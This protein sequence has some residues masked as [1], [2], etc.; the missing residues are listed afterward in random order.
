MFRSEVNT[1]RVMTTTMYKHDVACRSFMQIIEHCVSV[2]R[3]GVG[4]QGG[5]EEGAGGRGKAKE[6]AGGGGRRRRE[7]AARGEG[8]SSGLLA[9][10]ADARAAGEA[11]A[12][13]AGMSGIETIDNAVVKFSAPTW[14]V[15]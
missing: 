4:T 15:A 10:S 2:E 8:V 1:R 5:A 3:A 6:G 13:R 9:A 7:A 14:S 12:S 11:A